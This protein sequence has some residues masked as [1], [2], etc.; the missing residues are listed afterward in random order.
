M[1]AARQVFADRIVRVPRAYDPRR[2]E[3]AAALVG[4][5]NPRATELITGAAGSSPYINGLIVRDAEW[6]AAML[7]ETPENAFAALLSPYDGEAEIGRA[8]V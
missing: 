3:E 7:D 1:T 8:H 4:A 5:G 6:L 2:G